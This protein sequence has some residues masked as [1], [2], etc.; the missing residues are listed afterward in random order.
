[1]L[2]AAAAVLSCSEKPLLDSMPRWYSRSPRSYAA[3]PPGADSSA[4]NTPGKQGVYA[5]ALCFPEWANWREGDFRGAEAVLFRDSVEVA[6]CAMGT[7]PDPDRVRIIDG[8]LWTSISGNGETA[9]FCDGRHRLTF[10]GEELLKGLLI[11]GDTI[12]TLGQRPGGAGLCYRENG[13]EVFSSGAG[14]IL[15]TLYRD[16]GGTCFAWGITIRSG[17]AATTE[18]HI[19]RGADEIGIV[20]PNKDGAIYDI[21][22]RDGTVYR[23]ERRGESP[24][25]LCLVIGDSCHS[26]NVGAQE[27]IHLCRLLDQGGEMMIKGYSLMPGNILHWVRTREGLRHLVT[28]TMGVP[29]IYPDGDNLAYLT[30]GREGRVTKAIVCGEEIPATEEG[31]YLKIRSSACADF[32]GGVFAAALS[33]TSGRQHRI[34]LDGELI[35]LEF[36]GYFT[37]LNILE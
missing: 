30:T 25:S 22:V 32:R 29:D 17:D 34:F 12:L 37:S 6:R 33:D 10:P 20:N 9:V 14:T 31:L 23:S 24:S 28:S 21:R 4:W 8:H 27:D 11:R 15:G 35:P 16:D 1:M 7:L 19:M 36:N 26:M 2:A 5:A 18:Y 13:K 3:S